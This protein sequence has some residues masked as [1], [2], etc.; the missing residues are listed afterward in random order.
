MYLG[1]KGGMQ[2]GFRNLSG[3]N[4]VYLGVPINDT[5]FFVSCQYIGKKA[6][7]CDDKL[8]SVQP[9][10]GK[11]LVEQRDFLANYAKKVKDLESN[12]KSSDIH[13][14]DL[15]KRLDKIK[16]GLTAFLSSMLDPE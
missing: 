15:D 10:A 12:N 6:S 4:I 16:D 1:A 8:S 11:T 3:M 5:D 9:F 13:V 14:K 7:G 2:Y